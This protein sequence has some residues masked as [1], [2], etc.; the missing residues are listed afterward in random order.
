MQFDVYKNDNSATR[1]RFP[2]LL[3]VQADFLSDLESRVVVPLASEASFADKWL[4]GLM[5]VV[6]IK[7]KPYVAVTPQL[8]G[9]AHRDLGSRVANGGDVRAEL[10]AA[11]DL[12]FTGA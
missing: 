4:K 9:I 5:P 8:A 7:G 11:F 12:L 1:E 6:R 2:Y 3:D 10:T